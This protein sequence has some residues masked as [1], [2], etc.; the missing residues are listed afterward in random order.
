MRK[1]EEAFRHYEKLV[2]KAAGK[3]EAKPE[4]CPHCPYYREDFRYRTCT[5]ARCPF[6]KEVDVFR[7]QPLKRNSYSGNLSNAI[8]TPEKR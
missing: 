4:S 8:N 1:K 6:G 3:K 7:K 5:F 2:R